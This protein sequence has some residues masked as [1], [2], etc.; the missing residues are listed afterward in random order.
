VAFSSDSGAEGPNAAPAALGWMLPIAGSKYAAAQRYRLAI[1]KS[2]HCPLL[3]L[4]GGDRFQ[5]SW[6]F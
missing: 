1:P 5:L 4:Q 3:V 6:S 2:G